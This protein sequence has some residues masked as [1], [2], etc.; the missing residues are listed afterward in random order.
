MIPDLF[1]QLIEQF[2]SE[3]WVSDRSAAEQNSELDLVAVFKELD[4]LASLGFA[5]VVSNFGLYTNFLELDH[6]LVFS[7]LT[8]F[9]T[10]FVA[11]SSVI[12]EPANWWNGVG[13][14]F[15]KIETLFSR[16]FERVA[17]RN[18]ADLVTFVVD[19]PYFANT[20]SLVHASLNWSGNSL[21]PELY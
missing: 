10:L 4:C 2:A 5:I 13:R 21:P 3:F 8:L 9:T 14:N 19:E 15:D 11:K 17:G 16:H 18:N 6:M 12:H 20:N 7:G 1:A